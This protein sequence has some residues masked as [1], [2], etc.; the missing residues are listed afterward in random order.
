[1]LDQIMQV[2]KH[3]SEHLSSTQHG[4]TNPFVDL[5]L[6]GIDW[7]PALENV[8]KWF[9]RMADAMREKNRGERVLK[10]NLFFED[11]RILKDEA[12]NP[13][14]LTKMLRERAQSE[15]PDWVWLFAVGGGLLF[16]LLVL[17]ASG[18]FKVK[19]KNGTGSSE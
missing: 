13:D 16:V 1:M 3:G 10:M 17:L 4:A 19:T 18:V 6:D 11:L 5:V 9:D 12:K 7:D 8:N 2:D 15:I 14:R